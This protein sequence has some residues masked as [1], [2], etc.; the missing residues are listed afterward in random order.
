MTFRHAQPT[1]GLRHLREDGQSKKDTFLLPQPP[2]YRLMMDKV[3]HL[4]ILK[5]GPLTGRRQIINQTHHFN[6]RAVLLRL[7]RMSGTDESLLR[8][9]GME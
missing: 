4:S 3:H 9:A 2:K 8:D 5:A 6:R 7:S 1:L